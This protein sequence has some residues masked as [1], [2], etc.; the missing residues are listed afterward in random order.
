ML[1]M[2]KLLPDFAVEYRYVQAGANFGD[3]VSYLYMGECTG[4]KELLNK[5]AG[6]EE[7]YAR[8]GYKTLSLDK[9]TGL[10]GYGKSIDDVIGQ[11]RDKGEKPLFHAQIYREKFLGKVSPAVNLEKLMKGE[12]QC[13]E[14][15][16]LSTKQHQN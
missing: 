8:R 16:F 9:L 1:G 15:E 3:A 12:M 10:G 5:W 11:K 4:F 13:G 2:K 7:E 6:W 14:Y